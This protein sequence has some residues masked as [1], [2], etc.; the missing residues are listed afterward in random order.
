MAVILLLV[1]FPT[2]DRISRWLEEQRAHIAEI[3]QSEG[4][5]SVSQDPVDAEIN[6][7]K[8]RIAELERSKQ[9]GSDDPV[10]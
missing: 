4:L 2:R 1:T 7:L 6:Q 10:K 5:P 3:R 9:D 8:E